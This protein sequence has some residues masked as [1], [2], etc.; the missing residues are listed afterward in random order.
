MEANNR[1]QR[2]QSDLGPLCLQ[3]RLPKN[4]VDEKSRQQV[5]TGG[6]RINSLPP[7]DV[8]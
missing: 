2:K 4:I 5:V 7:S 6:L 3:Y 1:N 8:C